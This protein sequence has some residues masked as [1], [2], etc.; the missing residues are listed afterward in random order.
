MICA[1]QHSRF[2]GAM[3][4]IWVALILAFAAVSSAP[5]RAAAPAVPEAVRLGLPTKIPATGISGTAP[6]P[7]QSSVPLS[8]LDLEAPPDRAKSLAV[9][10][11]WIKPEAP[12]RGETFG[13][14]SPTDPGRQ[15][16]H[17]P[18]PGISVKVPLY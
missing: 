4:A 5:V 13:G 8:N 18:L 6:T 1:K 14:T 15:D 7:A 12:Y 16:R 10:P 11:A 2:S 17:L 9:G 3:A